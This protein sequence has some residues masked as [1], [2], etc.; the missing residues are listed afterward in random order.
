[1]IHQP[2]I[3]YECLKQ[4]AITAGASHFII[5]SFFKRCQVMSL[6]SDFGP[7][8]PCQS[9]R[10]I[11][12]CVLL[13]VRARVFTDLHPVIP[14]PRLTHCW[15]VLIC[16]LSSS[17]F[18]TLSSSSRMS[19]L[20]NPTHPNPLILLLRS[21]LPDWSSDRYFFSLA[22]PRTLAQQLFVTAGS[23]LKTSLLPSQLRVITVL[24]L[25]TC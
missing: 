17:S 25:L 6:P 16:Y 11:S 22:Q 9:L 2:H 23:S 24:D 19:R 14:G 20:L 3:F 13:S 15:S 12:T 1:M 18:P 7:F 5:L 21:C 10:K 8:A 4:K